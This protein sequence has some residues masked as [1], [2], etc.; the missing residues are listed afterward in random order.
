MFYCYGCKCPEDKISKKNGYNKEQ[1]LAVLTALFVLLTVRVMFLL[2]SL[3]GKKNSSGMP[4][5][6]E[7]QQ[8][9]PRDVRRV[10]RRKQTFAAD[11]TA[12]HRPH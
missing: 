5:I 6:P 2:K 8:R 1:I 7:P 12:R 10:R 11:R 9:T 3:A 4:D